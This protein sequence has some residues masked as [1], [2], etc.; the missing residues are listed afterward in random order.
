MS[1]TVRSLEPQYPVIEVTHSGA[2]SSADLRESAAK[3]LELAK[4]MG[5]FHVLTDCIELTDAPDDIA[6]LALG[7]LLR[8][9]GTGF[10]H[11][12]LW[13]K[14]AEARLAVDFWRTAEADFGVDAQVFVSREPAIE[15]LTS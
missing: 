6:L 4:G 8:T 10:R 11:A 12:L 14:D 5:A 1:S 13:P 7:D 3:A 9:A 2:V 15:W